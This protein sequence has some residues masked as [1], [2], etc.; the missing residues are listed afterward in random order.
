MFPCIS[1]LR[2]SEKSAVHVCDS[3]SEVPQKR[4]QQSFCIN[5][6]LQDDKSKITQQNLFQKSS[7][8]ITEFNCDNI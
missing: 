5:T 1:V 6:H 8:K 4:N 7:G 3:S 2:N